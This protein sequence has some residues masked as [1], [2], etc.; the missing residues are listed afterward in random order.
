MYTLIKWWLIWVSRGLKLVLLLV[1]GVAVAGAVFMA[2]QWLGIVHPPG[3]DLDPR[4]AQ[5]L[6]MA[7]QALGYSVQLAMFA[8]VVV[9]W[10]PDVFRE[11]LAGI[12]AAAE[13]ENGN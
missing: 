2:W 4:T 9:N 12:A 13:K 3:F 10:F 8:A 1:A 5:L 7:W 11:E 6:G